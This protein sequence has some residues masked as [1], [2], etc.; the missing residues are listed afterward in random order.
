MIT[1]GGSSNATFDYRRVLGRF[2]LTGRGSDILSLKTGSMAR[3]FCMGPGDGPGGFCIR[4]APQIGQDSNKP[5]GNQ[6]DTNG[7]SWV[8][9]NQLQNEGPMECFRIQCNVGGRED[10]M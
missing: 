7:S 8:L 3:R 1:N 2:L 4:W 5:M 9:Q 6:W 10:A